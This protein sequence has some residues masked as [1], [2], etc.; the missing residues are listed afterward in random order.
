MT[1]VG[2][3]PGSRWRVLIRF[4]LAVGAVAVVGGAILTLLGPLPERGEPTP[5]PVAAVPPAPNPPDRMPVQT[6]VAAALDPAASQP[7]APAARRRPQAEQPAT[8][9]TN[10]PD[11]QAI[12]AA[13]Q[14]EAPVRAQ[15]HVVLHPARPNGAGAIAERLTARTG[16]AAGQVEVGVPA[17]ARPEVAIRFYSENDHGLARRLGQELGRMG[18]TW[19]LENRA[20]RAPASRDQPVEVW[21]TD[22]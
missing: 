1:L 7:P 18:Y 15:A 5:T 17:E 21:L 6:P 3:G 13:V 14:R 11:V 19:R 12:G 4:W 2:D 20:G 22:R 9:P 10:P 16:L 8:P